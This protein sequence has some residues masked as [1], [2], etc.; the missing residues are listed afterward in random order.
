[1]EFTGKVRLYPSIGRVIQGSIVKQ[2]DEIFQVVER[3]GANVLLDNDEEVPSSDCKLL[4]YFIVNSKYYAELEHSDYSK[5]AVNHTVRCSTR[6]MLAPG[7]PGDRVRML[8]VEEKGILVP[9][10]PIT[11]TILSISKPLYEIELSSGDIVKVRRH[12]FRLESRNNIKYI[13]TII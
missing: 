8:K 3:R 2:Q 13:A 5:V 4:K 11:G 10:E 7:Y 1:M 9:I 12:F 6:S